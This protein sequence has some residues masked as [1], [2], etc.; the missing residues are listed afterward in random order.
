MLEFA[1]FFGGSIFPYRAASRDTLKLPKRHRAFA[2]RTR[3]KAPSAF[4]ADASRARS[5]IRVHPSGRAA[6]ADTKQTQ[7]DT[8]E[9]VRARSA[10]FPLWDKHQN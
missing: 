3:L 7:K 6:S 4:E 1:H 5:P 10:Q 9:E 8:K 2:R